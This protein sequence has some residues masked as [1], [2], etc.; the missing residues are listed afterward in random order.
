MAYHEGTNNKAVVAMNLAGS[1]LF[2]WN[3]VNALTNNTDTEKTIWKIQT[4]IGAGM[5]AWSVKMFMDLM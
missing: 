4:A 5:A 1:G 3:F 2:L